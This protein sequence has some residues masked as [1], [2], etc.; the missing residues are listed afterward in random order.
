MIIDEINLKV[1]LLG[2]AG[3]GK[4]AMINTYL[5]KTFPERYL[6]TIG[7][8][9]SHKIFK[10]KNENL[11]I[12]VNLWDVG[13]NRVFSPLSKSIFNNV[14][15]TIL[16][17]DLT[18]PKQ[19][20]EEIKKVYLANLEEH[21]DDSSLIVVG[22]KF[23]LV[24]EDLD[25]QE[26]YED[27]FDGSLPVILTSAKSSLNLEDSFELLVYNFLSNWEKTLLDENYQGIAKKFLNS[28]EK[29]KSDFEELLIK[30]EMIDSIHYKRKATPNIAKKQVSGMESRKDSESEITQYIKSQ[31]QMKRIDQAKFKLINNYREQLEELQQL[32]LSLKNVPIDSLLENINSTARMME[33]KK[34]EFLSILNQLLD[35]SEKGENKTDK[36]NNSSTTE[37]TLEK[38]GE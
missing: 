19:T 31:K 7:N 6:P 36:V 14:D 27:Y 26:L 22:N 15:A 24:Q 30:K 37:I 18:Q 17:F 28:I 21:I 9:I 1:L 29:E 16:V 32:I 8:N 23:D 38:V 25:M 11:Q 34:E 3:V 4:T 13:G 5:S 2:H 12:R 33:E 10:I 35:F 20:I